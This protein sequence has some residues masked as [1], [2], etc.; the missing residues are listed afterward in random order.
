MGGSR[1]RQERRSALSRMPGQLLETPIDVLMAQIAD[2]VCVVAASSAR[3]PPVAPPAQA[4]TLRADKRAAPRRPPPPKLLQPAR[5]PSV[6][7]P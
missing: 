2:D 4:L 6:P 7:R 1:P 3:K 5:A